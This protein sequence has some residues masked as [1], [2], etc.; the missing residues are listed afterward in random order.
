MLRENGYK[1]RMMK[2]P[3]CRFTYDRDFIETMNIA[4]KYLLD[5]GLILFASNDT[6]GLHMACSQ[7]E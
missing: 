7:N 6:N 4:K 1:P 2:C 3:R 5:M